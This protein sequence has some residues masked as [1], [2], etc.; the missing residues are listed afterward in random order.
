VGGGGS[1]GVGVEGVM[2][3]GRGGN[4]RRYVLDCMHVHDYLALM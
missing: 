1:D 4:G 3:E 2:E